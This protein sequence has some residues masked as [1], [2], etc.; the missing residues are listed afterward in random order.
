[1]SQQIQRN[2]TSTRE[3]EV[4]HEALILGLADN[5]RNLRV[6]EFTLKLFKKM[7]FLDLMEMCRGHLI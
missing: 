1:M 4:A 2:Q 6:R 3:L 5:L 7:L